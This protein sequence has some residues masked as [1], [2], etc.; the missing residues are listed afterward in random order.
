MMD[1]AT[2]TCYVYR[3]IRLD[4]NEPFYV[5]VGSDPKYRRAYN[6]GLRD[7]NPYWHRIAAKTDYEVE[8]ILDGLTYEESL[9]KEEEFINLYGRINNKTGILC[10]LTDGGKGNK[11]YITTEECKLK[12]RNAKLGKTLSKEHR[13]IL[14]KSQM[15]KVAQLNMDGKLIKVWDSMKSIEDEIGFR[16]NKIWHCCNLRK[17]QYQG[18][19]WKYFKDL[20]DNKEY[21]PIKNKRK[22][23]PLGIKHTENAKLANRLA[24]VIP[25]IQMTRKGD[26][27]KEWI[28]AYDA[29]REL[30]GGTGHSK[31][32]DCCRGTRKTHKN[33]TWKY[34][35]N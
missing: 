24:H 32:G 31:I 15:V 7:R 21:I 22:P 19:K 33:F 27:I 10:N 13:A 30:F 2:N 34:K 1:V 3:H 26:F 23:R 17:P 29:S 18:F 9:K 8:V 6:K 20:Y 25:V 5:G 11:G 28:C 14:G 12:Q 4:K 35:N 16:K